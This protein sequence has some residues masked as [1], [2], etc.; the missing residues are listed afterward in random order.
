[1]QNFSLHLL[2]YYV[3]NY[4]VFVLLLYIIALFAFLFF[5]IFAVPHLL[6]RSGEACLGRLL[7]G[8]S[9]TLS[10]VFYFLQE[11]ANGLATCHFAY[12]H[13]DFSLFFSMRSPHATRTTF[14]AILL[15]KNAVFFLSF[16]RLL[17]LLPAG[18]GLGS[19][20]A[21]CGVS[22]GVCLPVGGPNLFLLLLLLDSKFRIEFWAERRRGGT[23]S[24]CSV[25]TCVCV[26]YTTIYYRVYS[27]HTHTQSWQ[28]DS[29]NRAKQQANKAR[30]DFSYYSELFLHYNNCV[31]RER[32]RGGQRGRGRRRAK[33]S[34]RSIKLSG[35]P[36]RESEGERERE[37][38]GHLI[39]LSCS[40]ILRIQK[41]TILQI[42]KQ[43]KT[44]LW[45]DKACLSVELFQGHFWLLHNFC[46]QRKI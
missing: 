11:F 25:Y 35:S 10:V 42:K 46:L 21:V 33:S 7:G 18:I 29:W 38:A 32:G 36:L 30:I 43:K 8:Y 1:M 23:K 37:R 15:A 45:A 28:T 19:T 40:A 27:L 22:F 41:K 39:M 44:E 13:W 14:F 20:W 5:L 24:S 4:R 9:W 6:C 31:G 12:F 26:L 34:R 2:I 16:P 3:F 17:T